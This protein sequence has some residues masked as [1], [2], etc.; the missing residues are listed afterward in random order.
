MSVLENM[1]KGTDSTSTRVLIGVIVAVFIFWGAG[2]GS[3]Q[4]TSIYATINGV[5]VTDT[6]FR[7]TFAQAARAAGRNLTDE[8]AEQ[9]KGNVITSLIQQEAVTQEATRLG[10]TVSPEEL[11]RDIQRDPNFQGED[12]KFDAKLYER[13]LKA[14]SMNA[15]TWEEQVYRKLLMRKIADFVSRSVSVPPSEVRAAYDRD[16]TKLDLTFVRLPTTNFLDGVVVS[17]ADRD[18]FVTQNADKIKARYD[19]SYDRFYNLPKRYQLRTILLRTDI[20]G[21]DAAAVRVRLEAVRAEA[22]AG[23]DFESLA[24]RWSE[25]LSASNGGQLGIQPGAQLDPAITAAA[26]AAG[27]GKVTAVVETSRGLQVLLVEQIEDAKVIPLED[28]RNDI[29][30]SLL[31][32]QGAPKLVEQTAG[33]I[34]TAW[35]AAGAPPADVLATYRLSADTTGEFSLGEPEVPRL[36][37]DAALRAQLATAKVGYVIPTPLKLK[38][39]SFVVAVTSRTE[40]DPAAFELAKTQIEGRLRYERESSLMEQWVT[41]VVSRAKVERPAATVA[42]N[43]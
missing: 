10:I 8:E 12:G 17:D 41:D 21:A 40:P 9:L 16:E 3:S 22:V 26:D 43:P 31:K 32:E 19:E 42:A 30:V 29:A 20:A 38:G 28:A 7:R 15:P 13:L 23:A 5:A 24:K 25:D 39:A 11:Q 4:S 33:A 27:V 35:S 2:S 34:I 37:D 18:A 6:D 1:R 36:G 14:Q